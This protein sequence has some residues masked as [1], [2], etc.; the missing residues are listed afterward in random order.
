MLG[1]G[2]HTAPT[3][4]APS[5][6]G[7]TGPG[8]I[9]SPSPSARSV[10]H[11]KQPGNGCV[12]SPGYVAMAAR[13]SAAG[14]CSTGT[15]SSSTT[16]TS[17]TRAP[18]IDS[19]VNGAPEALVFAGSSA[20]RC[21]TANATSSGGGCRSVASIAGQDR[22]RSAPSSPVTSAATAPAVQPPLPETSG[23]RNRGAMV[24]SVVGKCSVMP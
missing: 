7:V 9:R 17:T 3:R 6:A 14:T 2:V 21:W 4:T 16:W 22:H 24:S 13:A 19:T 12:R 8:K 18:P 5:A 10:P 23:P 11:T 1:C 20:A 15:S